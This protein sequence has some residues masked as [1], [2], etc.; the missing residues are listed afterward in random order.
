MCYKESYS[1]MEHYTGIVCTKNYLIKQRVYLNRD[2]WC[3]KSLVL[4][5]GETQVHS[6]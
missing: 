5:H 6:T 2:F 4:A 1:R 3:S